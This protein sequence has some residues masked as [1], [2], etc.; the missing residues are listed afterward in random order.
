MALKLDVR[1]KPRRCG[2]EVEEQLLRIG[3][4]AISNAVRHA[5]ATEIHVGV[6]YEK[7]ILRLSVQDNGRGISQLDTQDLLF[8]GLTSMRE[9]AEKIGAIL[10]LTSHANCGTELELVLNIS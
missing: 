5:N 2:P 7:T 10:T 8:G 1:G 6:T 9:R 3:Q 4:E